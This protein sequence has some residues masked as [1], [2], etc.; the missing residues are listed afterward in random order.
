MKPKYK[1]SVFIAAPNL[2]MIHP[3]IALLWVQW[4]ISGKYRWKIYPVEGVIPLDRARNLCHKEFL[5]SGMDYL[6]FMDDDTVPPVDVLDRLIA[7]DV[8]IVSTVIQAWQQG[9]PTPVAYRWSKE[10]GGYLP[11]YGRGLEQVDVATLGCTLIKRKVMKVLPPGVFAFEESDEWQT[12]GYSEDF[13][14]CRKAKKAG[15][16]VYTDY[17]IL[18]D[19]RKKVNFAEINNLLVV[20]NG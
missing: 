8:D 19:R 9:G 20:N 1:P 14:F 3:Q 16:G 18:C 2:G 10:K 13:V 5:A 4:A 11:H 17:N 6:F 7:H 15:F 12:E